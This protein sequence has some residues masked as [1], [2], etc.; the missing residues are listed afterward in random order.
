MEK[1]TMC[2]LY[3]FED[4]GKKYYFET[5]VEAEMLR[6]CAYKKYDYERITRSKYVV[7]VS[8]V[9]K[10]L[11]PESEL[12]KYPLSSVNNVKEEQNIKN[13]QGKDA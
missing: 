2:V 10:I 4:N 1:V 12:Y 9:G 13:E 6:F 7:P 8:R 5:K 3:Y 11:V